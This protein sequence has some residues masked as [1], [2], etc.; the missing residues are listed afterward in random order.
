MGLLQILQENNPSDGKWMR[1]CSGVCAPAVLAHAQ[2]SMNKNHS[3]HIT[4]G[5]V[6]R[7]MGCYNIVGKKFN[8]RLIKV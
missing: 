5:R 8:L 6:S 4:P 7:I 3:D 2:V 1:A